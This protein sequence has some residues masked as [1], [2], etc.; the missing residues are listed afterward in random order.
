MTLCIFYIVTK[1]EYH[2]QLCSCL[3][4]PPLETLSRNQRFPSV[5]SQVAKTMFLGL[6]SLLSKQPDISDPTEMPAEE[7]R[8]N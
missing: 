6:S 8:G 3:R 2:I 1:I 5:I 7:A 4:L